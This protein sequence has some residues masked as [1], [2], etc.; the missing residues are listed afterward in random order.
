MFCELFC[1]SAQRR[2]DEKAALFRAVFVESDRGSC[3]QKKKGLPYRGIF[4]LIIIKTLGILVM[5][6]KGSKTGVKWLLRSG[7]RYMPA[8]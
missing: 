5:N 7:R 1:F 4:S 3:V 6:K 8:G 2:Q